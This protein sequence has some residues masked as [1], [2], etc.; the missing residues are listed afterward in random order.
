MP[1]CRVCAH[2]RRTEIDEAIAEG[3][4]LRDI[5][6]TFGGAS[7]DAVRRHKEAHVSPALVRL[8]T[9]LRTAAEDRRAESILDR[10]EGLYARIEG[11]LDRA[12]AQ[13]RDGTVLQASRN[14]GPRGNCWRR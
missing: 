8:G 2:E 12:E 9:R 14:S 10:M 6:A 1:S 13:G 4:S 11:L 5:A 7:K 3:R